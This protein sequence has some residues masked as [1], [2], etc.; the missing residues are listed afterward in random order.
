MRRAAVSIP[1]N[2]A[3]G[4]GRQT[5]KDFL[6]FL[7]IA[8][9]SLWELESQILI[10]ERLAYLSKPAMSKLLALTDEIGRMLNALCSSLN[11]K[12]A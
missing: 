7:W 10:T 9:G 8:R 3:E 11:R 6:H 4:Q 2:I 5:T 12:L 1:C